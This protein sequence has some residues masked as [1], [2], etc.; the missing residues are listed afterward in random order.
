MFLS[1]FRKRKTNKRKMSKC[2]TAK[3]KMSKR[4]TAKCKT[5]KCKTS[6]RTKKMTGGYSQEQRDILINVGLSPRFIDAM[7]S[8]NIGFNWLTSTVNTYLNEH[9][10][11][12]STDFMNEMLEEANINLD[13][14]FTD[15]E[16]NDSQYD[17]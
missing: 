3:R 6:K 1:K 8:N 2:K 14:G 12:T 4:K 17:E 10:D 15:Q 16:D 11:K 5:A 13:D 7:V 9:P